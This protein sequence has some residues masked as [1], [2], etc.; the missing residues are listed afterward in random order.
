VAYDWKTE[1]L[2]VFSRHAD[3]CQVR[4]GRECTCGPLGYRASIRDWETGNRSVSPM[5]ETIVEAL[6]WQ[7][8]QVASQDAS[9]GL[10]LDRGE[11]G[12]LI[13]EFLQAV[14]DGR[15]GGP[16]SR[17]DVRV[18]RGA[19]SYVDSELGTL[20]IQ[21][22]RRRHI[23][24][25]LDQ[26]RASGL[27]S[28]R[29]HSIVDALHALYAYALQRDLV[30]FSPV[31]ELQLPESDNGVPRSP[32]PRK[33][34][35]AP[36]A[37]PA[38][39]PGWTSGE[40]WTTPPQVGDPWTPPPYNPPPLTQPPFGQPPF[41]QPPSNPPP[42][43]PPPYTPPP[44]TQPPF[45]QPPFTQPPF[46]GVPS[47]GAHGYPTGGFPP[48]YSPTP[49]SW[50]GPL[51][52]ALGASPTGETQAQYDATMQE[53]WLWWTVRIIVIVFVLIALVLV[54]ESV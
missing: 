13:D 53:R 20:D 51:S 43:T 9:R 16:A 40:L 30:G 39:A 49:P 7:R 26:L 15:T 52:V 37:A 31:V 48:P 8:D 5:Y 36:A 14:E 54:A 17:E 25:L 33:P 3:T 45:T 2:G 44:Y 50:T 4:D 21:D 11:L 12:A 35:H 32:P 42:Y 29:I 10:A 28:A 23:Q 46:D 19:L 47:N 34:A 1:V 27:A 6:A 22:V 41:T 38:A 24:A 18:L